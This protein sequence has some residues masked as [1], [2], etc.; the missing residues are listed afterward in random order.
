MKKCNLGD[1]NKGDIFF[2]L[3]E[4]FVGYVLYHQRDL[5]GYNYTCV[6]VLYSGFRNTSFRGHIDRGL[7]GSDVVVYSVEDPKK[8]SSSRQY[9]YVLMLFY[10][11]DYV[12]RT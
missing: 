4:I 2:D 1:L 6:R 9:I 7:I 11:K 10:I 3:D 8:L 12:Y 5:S